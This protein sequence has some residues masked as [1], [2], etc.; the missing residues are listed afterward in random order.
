MFFLKIIFCLYQTCSFSV[1]CLYDQSFKGPLLYSFATIYYVSQIY[2]KHVW[3]VGLEIPNRS[4]IVASHKP[5]CFSPVSWVVNWPKRMLWHHKVAKIW[6]AHS[7]TKNK[8]IY[9][10]ETFRNS[11]RR[12]DTYLCIID[13]KRWILHNKWP[14]LHDWWLFIQVLILV[15]NNLGT[16]RSINRSILQYSHNII[17]IMVFGQNDWDIWLTSYP[18]SYFI[19]VFLSL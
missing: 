17:H 1:I 11:L 15:L 2:T 19:C 8:R 14:L 3:S 9:L 10:P 18:E 4:C 12:G 6:S 7:Q 16:N 13:M 5:L